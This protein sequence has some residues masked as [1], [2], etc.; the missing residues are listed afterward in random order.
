MNERERLPNRRPG[1]AF[2]FEHAGRR[3]TLTFA[4]FPDGRVAEVFIDAG[5]VDPLSSLA[6]ES[7]LLASIALQ[8]GCPIETLKHALAGRNGGPLAAGLEL[9]GEAA[10]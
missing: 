7:A 4:R 1:E 6:Q 3:W 5:R 8:H 10:R 9:V 2:D